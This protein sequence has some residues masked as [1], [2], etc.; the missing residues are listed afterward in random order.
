MCR[1]DAGRVRF[2]LKE[3]LG[4]LGGMIAVAGLTSAV[5]Y[6]LIR[7]HAA[8][9]AVHENDEQKTTRIYAVVDRE[10]KHHI[11]AGPHA[12]VDAAMSEISTRL[13]RIETL[14][15]EMR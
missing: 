9:A 8:N 11:D 15:E 7:G 14:L 13:T 5:N 1:V 6:T 3:W 4:I 12:G 10:F 2:G